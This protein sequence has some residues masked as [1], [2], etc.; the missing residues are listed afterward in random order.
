VQKLLLQ[1]ALVP[2]STT[3][4]VFAFG[5]FNSVSNDTT[6]N[7][8]EHLL[9]ALDLMAL[10]FIHSILGGGA[11]FQ[12]LLGHE[13]NRAGLFRILGGVIV[14]ASRAV[15]GFWWAIHH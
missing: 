1:G 15:F 7:I 14:L 6:R 4:I 9:K 12:I 2:L 8:V 11:S 3:A 10:G 5:D 13:W